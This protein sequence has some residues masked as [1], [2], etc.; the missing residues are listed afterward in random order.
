[1]RLR[2]QVTRSVDQLSNR[3]EK[4][5]S[6]P[7]GA[8]IKADVMAG[9]NAAMATQAMSDL[10]AD[11]ASLKTI[12]SATVVPGTPLHAGAAGHRSEPGTPAA[13]TAGGSSTPA[14]PPPG[15]PNARV[16]RK[17]NTSAGVTAAPS[18]SAAEGSPPPPNPPPGLGAVGEGGQPYS[19]GFQEVLQMVQRG[20]VPS[21]VAQVARR[22]PS[23]ENLGSWVERIQARV[24]LPNVTS[25]F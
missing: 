7:S 8:E 9:V 1:M 19:A 2:L 3:V 14:A 23:L 13:A 17:L 20:G 12:M 4:L 22:D 16:F 5:E 21:D 10:K 25:D 24:P 11:L 6:R 15:L 18:S